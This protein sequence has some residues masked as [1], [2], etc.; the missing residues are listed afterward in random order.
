MTSRTSP[1]RL[2][3]VLQLSA[4][5]APAS[6]SARAMARPIPREAPGTKAVLPP[7]GGS[8]LAVS[9]NGAVIISRSPRKPF[10]PA[11]YPARV[12]ATSLFLAHPVAG[13]ANLLQPRQRANETEHDNRGAVDH[14]EPRADDHELLGQ[15]PRDVRRGPHRRLPT[16][17]AG[18]QD[19]SGHHQAKADQP[20][21]RQN[22]YP[23]EF[24]DSASGGLAA[25][26]PLAF[27]LQRVETFLDGLQSGEDRLLS[28]PQPLEQAADVGDAWDAGAAGD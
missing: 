20:D 18:H 28:D 2:P 17:G 7:T 9:T 22:E 3:A 19:E 8:F 6:A 11:S 14:P 4:T 24:H 27:G 5:S 1:A 12:R 10:V 16:A 21:C 26:V 13:L 25:I 23:K 15:R